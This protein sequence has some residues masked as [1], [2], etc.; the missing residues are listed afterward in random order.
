MDEP[1]P[2]RGVTPDPAPNRRKL[3][4]GAVG[5]AALMFGLMRTKEVQAAMAVIDSGAIAQLANQLN[6]LKRQY[7]QLTAIKKVGDDTLAGLGKAGASLLPSSPWQSNMS[8]TLRGLLPDYSSYPDTTGK[9]AAP[10]FATV[11]QAAD[12]FK[13]M[14]FAPDQDAKKK[15][16]NLK[17]GQV[18]DITTARDRALRD[19]A[20]NGLALAAHAKSTVPALSTEAADIVTSAGAAVDLRGQVAVSN[21]ALAAI[22]QEMAMQRSL[23]ASILENIAAE[24]T[25]KIP[26]TW[27][28]ADFD[29]SKKQ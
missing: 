19:A 8:S 10:N 22:L 18:R 1:L 13:N 16:Q 2:D 4:M 29:E 12:Y 5:G 15:D 28:T 23:F 21:R 20:Q 25:R 14:L 27:G 24:N 11:N 17:M 6:E 26:V 7:E 3:L 9:R